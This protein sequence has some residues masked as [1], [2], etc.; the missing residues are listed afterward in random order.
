MS[1][2]PPQAAVDSGEDAADIDVDRE[3]GPALTDTALA[4][5]ATT[6][7]VERVTPEVDASATAAV[8]GGE[9]AANVD[10]DRGAGP[11]LTDA[12]LARD[13]TAAAVKGSLQRSTQPKPQSTV[14][15]TQ[16][17]ST[18]TAKQ[19]P[20]SQT[21]LSQAMPQPPQLNGI[22]PEVGRSR[23]HRRRWGDA[24]DIDVDREAGPA[25]TDTALA[26]DAAAATVEGVAPEVDATGAAVGQARRRA[27]LPRGG[28][29][30]A[31]RKPG[32]HGTNG[33]EAEHLATRGA[34]SNGT[35]DGIK[36]GVVHG[37]LLLH[38]T[39]SGLPVPL[40]PQRISEPNAAPSTSHGVSSWPTLQGW[41]LSVK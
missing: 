1:T 24:A 16:P 28:G 36:G 35:R 13:A 25:F 15:R 21:P 8:D 32:G 17:I 19:V 34:C 11:T 7:A 41:W 23:S 14:G 26:G 5:D 6:A 18:L 40:A 29:P 33:K 31:A 3:A 38:G 22:A 10:M 30:R 9:D 2:H 20:P 37:V 12:A 27:G 4:G 39:R